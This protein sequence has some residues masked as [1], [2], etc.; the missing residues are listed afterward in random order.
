MSTVE[1]V[2]APEQ[3]HAGL[4][5]PAIQQTLSAASDRQMSTR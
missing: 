3:L 5:H 2:I 1:A 4:Y